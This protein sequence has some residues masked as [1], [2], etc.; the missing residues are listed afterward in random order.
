MNN[1]GLK[2]AFR[3]FLRKPLLPSLNLF[4][5]SLGIGCFLVISLYLYQENSYEVGFNDYDRI[6]RVEESFFSMGVS[7]M[8]SSNLAHRLPEMPQVELHTRFS[9]FNGGFK[10]KQ[11]DERI[12]LARAFSVD[13]NFFKIFNHQ[14]IQGDTNEVFLNPDEAVVSEATARR[15]F[16]RTDV[17]GEFIELVDFGERKIVGVV[18][19]QKLKSHLDFDIAISP[20]STPKYRNPSWFG[21]GGYSYVKLKEGVLVEDFQSVIDQ[22]TENEVFPVIHP[23]QNLTFQE[24]S[25]SPSKIAFITKPIRDIYLESDVQFEI[26]TNGDSQVRL[27]LRI[28]GMIILVVASINFMNLTTAKA[29]YRAQEVGVRKVMGAS[30]RSLIISFLKESLLIT[31]LATIIGA[32]ISELF[33]RIVNLTWNADISISL[34]SYPQLLAYLAVFT[35][36]LGLLSGAYP[37]FYLS[38]ARMIPL[39][40]GM[41]LSSV[42]NVSGASG[43]RNTLV[44]VQFTISITLIVSSFFIFKQISFL[45]N[46]DLGFTKDEVMVLRNMPGIKEAKYTLR[47][48]LLR[49][50]GITEAS[51]TSRVPADGNNSTTATLL[52]SETSFTLSHFMTDE[53]LHEV[54]DFELVAGE[55]FD[56]QKVKY[57]SQV[58]INR[59][60]AIGLGLEDPVGTIFG[61]YW[62]I[63]GVVEDFYFQGLRDAV[64]PAMFMYTPEQH[65]QLAIKIDT[66]LVTTAMVDEI[67]SKF[68][69][70]PLEYYFLDQNLER[71]LYKEEQNAS[72]VLAFTVFAVLISCLGLFG[73]AA[74][75]AEQRKHEFGIRRVLGAGLSNLMKLFSYQFVKLIVISSVIAIPLAVYGLE[76]WLNSFAYRINLTAGYF[77]VTAIIAVLISL[78]TLA[79]QTI[80]IS[81]TNPVDTLRNE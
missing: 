53:Y 32:G 74:F 10:I 5:L 73:L 71:Q 75:S 12:K 47:E 78:V 27:I 1:I 48:E 60:A 68:T 62:T 17:I 11:G 30:H 35:L 43:L 72:A 31:T 34:M 33:I 66:D 80:Q 29:S 41:R 24:W 39:L 28:I 49:L 50:P 76:T 42:L 14:F 21:I 16:D 19:P 18:A 3:A 79:V 58:V 13:N 52:D 63:I 4:G 44:I 81:R 45:R 57:D 25:E 2:T 40:K 54:M 61:K 9:N 70:E 20:L 77:V 36:L 7:A 46:M 64:S 65:N 37:A 15:L 67:W 55:W 56:P 26:Y 38:S 23:D 51:F 59:S 8:S 22:M 69:Q 6:Y